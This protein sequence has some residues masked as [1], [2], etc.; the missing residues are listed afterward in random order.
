MTDPDARFNETVVFRVRAGDPAAISNIARILGTPYL[1]ITRLRFAGVAP[2]QADEF[3]EITNLGGGPQDM[4]GWTVRTPLRGVVFRF[5]A[6]F[7]MD[8][9]GDSPTRTC[10][11]YTDMVRPESCGSESLGA[12]DVWPDR[13]GEAVLFFDA[14]ALLGDATL[15]SADLANQPPPPNV[16]SVFRVTPRPR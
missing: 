12:R 16:Q 15:Y 13:A 11:I 9:A 8:P 5:P 10:R 2:G 6:G 3:I 4:T 14:L 7:I 1:K